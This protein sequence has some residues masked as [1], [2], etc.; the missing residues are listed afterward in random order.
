MRSEDIIRL[1]H[2]LDEAHEACQFVEGLSFNE[3]QKDGKTV[4]AVIR[5]IEIIGEA[6]SKLS[7]DFRKGHPEIPWLKISGMRNR[8][9]HVYFDID[10]QIIWHTV[11]ENLPSLI[12]QIQSILNI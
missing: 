3:F 1:K 11:K 9:I 10:Y 8:L 2:I 5:S 6:A 12:D 7:L 4:R